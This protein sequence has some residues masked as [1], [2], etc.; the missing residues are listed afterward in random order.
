MIRKTTGAPRGPLSS[1]VSG[2]AMAFG[3]LTLFMLSCFVAFVVNV[4][5]ASS[6]KLLIQ[7]AADEGAYAGAVALSNILSEIA[8]LNDAQAHL[9][10]HAM[11]KAVDVNV[12][13]VLAALEA[14]GPPYPGPAIVGMSDAA[15]AYAAAYQDAATWFPRL[16]EWGWNLAKMQVGFAAAG[17]QLVR[18]EIFRAVHET[19]GTS[20]EGDTDVQIAVFPDFELLPDPDGYYRFDIT[21]YQENPA[22]W[23]LSGSDGL[24]VEVLILTPTDWSV[25]TSTGLDLA[26]SHPTETKYVLT[27]SAF[28]TMT[29]DFYPGLG[30][31]LEMPGFSIE[32]GDHGGYEISG[33][34][35][36]HEFRRGPDGQLQEW[37]GGGWQN[38]GGTD[39]VEVDGVQIPVAQNGIQIGEDAWVDF[40][41]LRVRFQNIIITLAADNVR[42]EGQFGPARVTVDGDHVVVNGLTTANP[43]G[44]WRFISDKI[45]HRMSVGASPDA[46]VY[47]WRKTGGYLQVEFNGLRFGLDHAI[48]D[49]DPQT[50]V[51]PWAYKPDANPVGWFDTA[52][53]L[54]RGPKAYH[55][56]RPCWHPSDAIC[57]VHGAGCSGEPGNLL[58]P[59]LDGG[60]HEIAPLTGEVVWINCDI[61]NGALPAGDQLDDDGDG[62][63]DV[64]K[65]LAD[66]PLPA[67]GQPAYRSARLVHY[68][69][70]LQP[71]VELR[72]PQPLVLT[73]DFFK[74]G[75]NVAV[76]KRAYTAGGGDE[77]WLLP[78]VF[79]LPSDSTGRLAYASA[80][81]G[82]RDGVTGKILYRFD[83]PDAETRLLQRFLW[84]EGNAE[85]LYVGDW[86]ARLWSVRDAI[87]DEDIDAAT[88]D[89]GLT[90]LFR[91]LQH[92]AW[93]TT[94]DDVQPVWGLSGG[95]GLDLTD[96][97]LG[98]VIRH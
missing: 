70:Y 89:S 1:D 2:Q 23:L 39:T 91:G 87:R 16:N 27:S 64:R 86:E 22:G 51:P 57:P 75:I 21:R 26:V 59:P 60:W 18:R 71:S 29:F 56:T 94:Y 53:G 66:I 31:V 35:G 12:Y 83:G 32:P 61:C 84:V 77:F 20:A 24:W 90:Y 50:G 82:P 43:E 37:T 73:E 79:P 72:V 11:R 38:L 15:G 55:Q 6:K 33:E 74:F 3:A 17:P 9:Y 96:P 69:T 14:H 40:D 19:L 45:R 52:T 42:I 5:Q 76:W 80:K 65:Y 98:D 88:G 92:T 67:P 48:G 81:C 85:N 28:G 30:W 62:R 78:Q 97:A 46:Y 25:R 7:H 49:N 36:S 95:M 63:S 58:R 68:N 8:W 13:G 41:P 93:H 10:Y 47:E 4:G 44:I 34:G 54:P